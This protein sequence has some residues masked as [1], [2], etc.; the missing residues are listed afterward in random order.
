MSKTP[1]RHEC[2]KSH[3]RWTGTREDMTL[4]KADSGLV[5]EVCP[6]CL[7]DTFYL[8]PVPPTNAKVNAVNEWLKIIGNCGR[9]FFN[10]KDTL[11]TMEQDARGRVWFVDEY[12]R[13]RIYTHTQ[14]YKRWHGFNNGGTLRRLI[15]DLRD[16]IKKDIKLNPAYFSHNKELYCGGHPWGYSEEDMA[17]IRDEGV[18]LGVVNEVIRHET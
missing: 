8:K 4:S 6:K 18:R 11:A 16:V 15:E 7:G 3:C 14:S 2:C 10:H 1:E 5:F 13:R 12:S 9:K 17:T